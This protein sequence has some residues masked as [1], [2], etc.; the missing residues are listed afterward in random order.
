[1]LP[2]CEWLLKVPF[3]RAVLDEQPVHRI[4][5]IREIGRTNGDGAAILEA[6][7]LRAQPDYQLKSAGYLRE[8]LGKAVS[9]RRF[10]LSTIAGQKAAPVIRVLEALV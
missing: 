8:L 5:G 1:L 10:S 2:L 4:F 3:N 7:A 6:T 9:D